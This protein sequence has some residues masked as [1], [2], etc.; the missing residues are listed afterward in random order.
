[1]MNIGDDEDEKIIYVDYDGG[2]KL[3]MMMMINE[4]SEHQ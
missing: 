1:M 4:G 2:R 3:F